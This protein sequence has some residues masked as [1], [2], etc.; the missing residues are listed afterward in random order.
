MILK[1]VSPIPPSVNSYLNYRVQKN[2]YNGKLFVQAYKS[3]QS[4]KYENIFL[5]ICKDEIKKQNW[6][7]PDK[8]KYIIVRATFYFQ[9]PNLDINNHWKLPLDSF[10]QA[11]VYHDDSRVIEGARRI[12][13]DKNNPR[14]EFEIWE[15]PFIGIFDSEDEFEGFKNANCR[16]CKKK[17]EKCSTITRA[18]E[19]RLTGEID[20]D[21]WLCNV[22]KHKVK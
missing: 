5:K 17:S 19:N 1:I 22:R 6:I 14:I 3:E 10:K 15:A 2:K 16:F 8:N 7:I 20:I 21:T 11:E 13:I 18:L 4:L 9:R 12:Y